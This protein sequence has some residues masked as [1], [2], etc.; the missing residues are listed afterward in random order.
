MTCCWCRE[1][2]KKNISI[3]TSKTGCESK[4]WKSMVEW[5]HRV[6]LERK[7]AL[8][9]FVSNSRVTSEGKVADMIVKNIECSPR[10]VAQYSPSAMR[11]R[12]RFLRSPKEDDLQTV[13]FLSHSNS[14]DRPTTL[15]R[16]SIPEPFLPSQ[17]LSE[18]EK[19]YLPDDENDLFHL[20][21]Y[22]DEMTNSPS[23]EWMRGILPNA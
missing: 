8:V 23:G 11:I 15:Q 2:E 22:G 9:R 6:Y 5:K 3:S 19:F 10:G 13:G 20:P 1:R 18:D 4:D 16:R 17:A 21:G 12:T 7:R 14:L